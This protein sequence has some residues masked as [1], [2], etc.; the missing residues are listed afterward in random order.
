MLAGEDVL[1]FEK[2][3]TWAAVNT[4]SGYQHA[5]K[6]A[7][8]A[9]TLNNTLLVISAQFDGGVSAVVCVFT[10]SPYREG[11]IISSA[12]TRVFLTI[13]DGVHRWMH[14]LPTLQTDAVVA[15]GQIVF[16][17]PNGGRKL[18]LSGNNR[19]SFFIRENTT[20]TPYHF[21]PSTI[22][23]F[24]VTAVPFGKR[25][26]SQLTQLPVQSSAGGADK[27][28]FDLRIMEQQQDNEAH[29]IVHELDFVQDFVRHSLAL[30][31]QA[32]AWTLR[33][34]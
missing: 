13:Q 30:P 10:D 12:H 7:H 21:T 19:G 33:A 1:H 23:L 28:L 14:D 5:P 27:L 17:S 9:T 6:I 15:A 8:P 20:P 11:Q 18:V 34:A 32:R 22:E 25:A 29:R 24:H 26:G 4:T 3:E 2:I 16:L 31:L